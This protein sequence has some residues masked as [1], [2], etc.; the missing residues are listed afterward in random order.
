MARSKFRAGDHVIHKSGKHGDVKEIIDSMGTFMPK[1]KWRQG[2]TEIVFDSEIR[3]TG[4]C[5]TRKGCPQG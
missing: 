4:Q 5:N 3:G 2:G 1:V